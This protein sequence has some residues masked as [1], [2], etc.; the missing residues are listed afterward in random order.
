MVVWDPGGSV[1]TSVSATFADLLAGA[2][3]FALFDNS[4]LLALKSSGVWYFLWVGIAVT[5]AG[6][7]YRILFGRGG[8]GDSALG[9]GE[10]IPGKGSSASANEWAM[11]EENA[12]AVNGW[13]PPKAKKGKG[14]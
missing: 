2:G 3:S 7:A 11:L 14:A 13:K 1:A 4:F 10:S 5:V 12:K 6:L 9:V 8:V